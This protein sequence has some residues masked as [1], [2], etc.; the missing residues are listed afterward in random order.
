MSLEAGETISI[1]F[2][3]QTLGDSS[4]AFLLEWF[5]FS[6]LLKVAR[7][8]SGSKSCGP[9]L[10]IPFFLFV[11]LFEQF[12]IAFQ[13]ER[14][15]G[16]VPFASAL[17]DVTKHPCAHHLF[18]VLHHYMHFAPFSSSLYPDTGMRM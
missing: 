3:S 11:F 10:A 7:F 9:V 5:P 16:S 12:F 2:P 18:S 4:T 17:Y 15:V 8:C 13:R 1:S 6:S 14:E